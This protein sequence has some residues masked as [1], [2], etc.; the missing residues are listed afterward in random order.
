M[1]EKKSIPRSKIIGMQVYDPEAYY[2][3]TVKDVGLVPGETA[4]FTLII[5]AKTG[6]TI[7]VPWK[8]VEKVGDIIILKEKVEIP[9]P[10]TPPAAP[11][12]PA[13]T[14][15]VEEKGKISLPFF[16][17]KEERICPKCGKP[18]TWIEQYK[19]WYCYNCREY[20]PP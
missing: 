13:P 7:E 14:P 6:A 12:A 19:R 9:S 10:P 1:S 4:E 3:G 2:V 5:Q 20:L 18:A 11:V 15:T 16:K 8:N 17:K